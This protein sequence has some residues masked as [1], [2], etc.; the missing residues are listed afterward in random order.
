MAI[1]TSYGIFYCTLDPLGYVALPLLVSAAFYSVHTLFSIYAVASVVKTAAIV[2][3]TGWIS[4]FIGHGV[5]EKRAP[6][7]FDNLLQALVLAPFFIMF[8]VVFAVGLRR[9]LKKRM[10]N[11]A[12]VLVRDFRQRQKAETL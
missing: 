7:L 5:Y 11:R 2:H 12:G 8:E 6:A 1:A 10:D 9:D 3:A 4:Q